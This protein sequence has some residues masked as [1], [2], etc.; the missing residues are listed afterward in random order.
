MRL[1]L[2]PRAAAFAQAPHPLGALPCALDHLQSMTARAGASKPP[3]S[4]ATPRVHRLWLAHDDTALVHHSTRLDCTSTQ[5]PRV[6]WFGLLIYLPHLIT[7]SLPPTAPPACHRRAV[8]HIRRSRLLN[9]LHHDD[10]GQR[11]VVQGQAAGGTSS[12]TCRT[13]GR[14][15]AGHTL[16]S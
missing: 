7:H 6:S 13:A 8:W 3:R 9:T 5:N 11:A 4:N 16:P 14:T 10:R 15:H 1:I 12:S 2:H